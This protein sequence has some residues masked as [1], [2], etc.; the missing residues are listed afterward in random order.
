MEDDDTVTEITFPDPLDP[1]SDSESDEDVVTATVVA[2]YPLGTKNERHIPISTRGN[3]R[4]QTPVSV[5]R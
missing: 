1:L 5:T 2:R 4:V 3:G